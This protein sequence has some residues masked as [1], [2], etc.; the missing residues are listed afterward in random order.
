MDTLAVEIWK[1]LP[2][3]LHWAI[4]PFLTWFLIV[5]LTLKHEGDGRDSFL[6]RIK[7]QSFQKFYFKHLKEWLNY[8]AKYWFKDHQKIL[9]Q[10]Q[11]NKC[12]NQ[13]N[14]LI[15]SRW[16]FFNTYT[17][18]SYQFLLQLALLY[19]LL[20]LLLSWLFTS[21]GKIGSLLVLNDNL[22]LMKRL[23]VV[24]GLFLIALFI[25]KNGVKSAGSQYWLNI[26]VVIAGVF[27]ILYI[28]STDS[29]FAFLGIVA[30]AFSL[31]FSGS[32]AFFFAGFSAY[33]TIFTLNIDANDEV[34]LV[35]IATMAGAVWCAA[36]GSIGFGSSMAIF[37]MAAVTDF[38]QPQL[39]GIMIINFATMNIYYHAKFKL[40]SL[41]VFWLGFNFI[42]ILY[43]LG[44]VYW[45]GTQEE[46]KKEGLSV[47]VFLGL[48][49]IINA[50]FDWISLGITRSLLYS[51]V[52]KVHGGVIAFFWSLA[53]IIVALLLM[54]AIVSASTG[55]IALANYLF[56]L[57]GYHDS[58]IDL[59]VMF[60]DLRENPYTSQYL[61]LY[62]MFMSTLIP[63]LSH[64]IL[65]AWSSISWI[66]PSIIKWLTQGWKE[67]QQK[68][69]L[70]KLLLATS[71]Y[72]I[73]LPIAL[74]AP[75]L[76]L[77]LLHILLIQ[78]GYAFVIGEN[79]LD[80]MEQLARWINP[81][82]LKS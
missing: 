76:V 64:L 2:A 60:N 20:F 10:R 70:P 47:L 73:F 13:K 63:T 27:A 59:A 69:N 55:M 8:I 19:P 4:F 67:D 14:T 54:L 43:L 44:I 75:I 7:K 61:W 9:V 26:V 1:E 39:L 49:P 35:F 68:N 74:F 16:G 52:D 79:L 57:G 12:Q 5:F 50:L 78:Q 38:S 71:Y 66:K 45:L 15:L 23:L 21:Q 81:F 33:A 28:T 18:S 51:I 82:M 62:V 36:S 65:A 46:I 24:V 40:N 32:Y 22:P 48:L 72:S 42:F 41:K 25:K 30:I 80:S 11:H 58:I 56:Q 53:D 77:F 37:L 29:D 31:T 17:E 3:F 34:F 6:F